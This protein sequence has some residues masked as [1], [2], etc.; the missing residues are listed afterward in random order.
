MTTVVI[1]EKTKKGRIILDLIREMNVGK[2]IEEKKSQHP[3]FNDITLQAIK[4][5]RDGETVKCTNFDDYLN[6]VK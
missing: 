2:I 5:A 1:N 6:K 3:V 4:E